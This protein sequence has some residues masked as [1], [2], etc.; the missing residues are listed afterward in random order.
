A[1]GD[2]RGSEGPT[3]GRAPRRRWVPRGSRKNMLACT[4]GV[5]I[6]TSSS[7][8]VLVDT[9]TGKVIAAAT[10]EHVVQRPHEG[11]VEMDARIW[12][13]EFVE[14]TRRMLAEVSDV[15][16]VGVGVSGMGPCV[17]LTDEH[18]EPVRPAILYGVDT[19]AA[20]IRSEER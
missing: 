18:D 16:I 3:A 14:L 19:R 9:A 1:A 17:L 13:D 11:W 2:V 12:W 8:G 4:I 7:K 5:D 10:S 6:G 15:E 20:G